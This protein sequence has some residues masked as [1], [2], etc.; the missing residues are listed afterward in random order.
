MTGTILN[1]AELAR[2]AAFWAAVAAGARGRAAKASAELAAAAEAEYAEQGVAP[3]WRIR[4][5]GTIPLA[6]SQDQV[7][8]VDERA[9]LDWVAA[10]YPTEVEETVRVRPAFDEHLR[11]GAAKRGDPPC[12]AAGEPIPGVA[13]VPGGR[14]KGISLRLEPAAKAGAAAAAAAYLE[15]MPPVVEVGQ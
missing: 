14:P 11:K 10:R 12:D 6:L 15:A 5:L 3:T 8:V 2:Q 13:F 4:G 1:R 9:Y 7:V